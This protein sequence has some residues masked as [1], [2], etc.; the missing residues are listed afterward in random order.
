VREEGERRGERGKGR[1]REE[2]GEKGEGIRKLG[3]KRER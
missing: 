1:G 2:G 3:G